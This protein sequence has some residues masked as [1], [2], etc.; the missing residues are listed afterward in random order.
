[1]T[2][3]SQ[4]KERNTSKLLQSKKNGNSLDYFEKNKKYEIGLTK[5]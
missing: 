2:T 4:Q 3:N 5:F 1:M